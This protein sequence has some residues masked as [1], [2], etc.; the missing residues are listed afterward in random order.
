[1]RSKNGVS[2]IILAITIIVM[3]IIAG[4][5]IISL[6]E[7][8]VIDEAKDSVKV[9]NTNAAKEQLMLLAI[10]SMDSNAD[11]DF[12]K[13][14]SS[15]PEGIEKVEGQTG[16]YKTSQG[17]IFKV[18]KSGSVTQLTEIPAT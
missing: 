6:T 15:L 11:V 7:N 1:M 4:A 17:D 5:V 14:D 10:G 16:I 18:N 3:I 2:L 13:L 12:T 8:D 9:W